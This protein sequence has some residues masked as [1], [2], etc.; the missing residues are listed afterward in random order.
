MSTLARTAL[1]NIGTRRRGAVATGKASVLSELESLGYIGRNHGLTDKGSIV[2]E[3]LVEEEER[4]TF[5]DW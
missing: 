4:N 5:G 2:R 1:I 3:L